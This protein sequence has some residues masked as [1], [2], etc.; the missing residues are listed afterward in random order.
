MEISSTQTASQSTSSFGTGVESEAED[1]TS[2]FET[3][4][5]MLTV[6]LQNQDPL[7]PT[8]ATDFAVQLATFSNVEQQV[9]TNDLLKEMVAGSS[10]STL[11][12]YAGWVGMEG[13]APVSAEFSGSP[14]SV[15]PDIPASADQATFV[16]RNASGVDILRMAVPP[17][18]N[19]IEW[20]GTD[21]Y[22]VTAPDGFYSFHFETSREGVAQAPT[23]GSVYATVAE[24]QLVNGDPVIVFSGGDTVLADAVSAIRAPGDST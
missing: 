3:F 20:D 18:N 9:L 14:I 5:R 6:Q 16:V 13:R 10:G 23:Q 19:P 21:A 7:N 12:Q 1:V 4:L 17:G 8:E 2:D 11:G 24:A 15:Q 22:G